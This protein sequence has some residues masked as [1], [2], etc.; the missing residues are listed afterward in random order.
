MAGQMR[1]GKADIH[2][3][4][5]HRHGNCRWRRDRRTVGQEYSR[6]VCG[7]STEAAMAVAGT[8]VTRQPLAAR[9]RR[10][11]RFAPYVDR[12]DMMLWL[13]QAHRNLAVAG[14]PPGRFSWFPAIGLTAGH[15]EGEVP[16]PEARP[17]AACFCSASMSS[18]PSRRVTE[19]AVGSTRIADTPG[20][21][22][23]VDARDARPCHG[24]AARSKGTGCCGNLRLVM[25]AR[26]IKPRCRWCRGLEIFEIGADIAD[27]REG[28]GWDLPG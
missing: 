27:L 2:Q 23:R 20:Q 1:P 19:S 7:A 16:M 9:Q 4:A 22:P 3:F 8:M 24:H 28:E 5:D 21:R 18:L 26:R 14:P 12:H 15:F 13:G 6:R 11:L 17:A 25:S 10:I